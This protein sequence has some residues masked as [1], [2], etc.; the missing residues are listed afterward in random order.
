MADVAV[1]RIQFRLR[2]D[3]H[4]W[5]IPDEMITQRKANSQELRRDDG[6]IIKK[7]L[8]EVTYKDDFNN[9]EQKIACYLD[10][11]KALGW[12]YRN[13]AKRQYALQ[14]WK[15][16]IIYPDFIFALDQNGKEERIMILETKGEH[17]DN[18][19]TKYKQKELN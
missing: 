3:S 2:T 13:V 7:N 18:L 10:S 16:N 17:L 1:E 12:W 9:Y 19:D 8:F 11:E 15:K 6:Q 5:V 4:N 14:G